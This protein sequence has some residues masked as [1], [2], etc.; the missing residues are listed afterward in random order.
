[1]QGD[2]TNPDPVITDFLR[3]YERFGVPFN[4][5]FNK[6][7]PAGLVL[8]EILT[9]DIV[10]KALGPDNACKDGESC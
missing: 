1:M 3:K 10:L 7:N 6:M 9:P 4:I 5:V 2:W 8:P